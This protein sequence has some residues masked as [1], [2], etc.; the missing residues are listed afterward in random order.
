[1]N[2]K[3]CPA[4]AAQVAKSAKAC[5]KCGANLKPKFSGAGLVLIFILMSVL[6]WALWNMFSVRF[7]SFR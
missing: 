3:P 1:M 5:P 7:I 2:L 4:C 6:I